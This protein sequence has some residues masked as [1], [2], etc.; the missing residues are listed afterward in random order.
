[1]TNGARPGG[2]GNGNKVVKL[3]AACRQNGDPDGRKKCRDC[4]SL[5]CACECHSRGKKAETTGK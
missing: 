3:S 1:M 2:Y 4:S 5:S